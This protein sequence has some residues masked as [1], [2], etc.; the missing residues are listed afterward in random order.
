MGKEMNEKHIANLIRDEVSWFNGWA[1]TQEEM[2][3]SCKKAA[4]KVCA[5]LENKKKREIK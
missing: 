4:Y 5:Y 3:D 1:V 2:E